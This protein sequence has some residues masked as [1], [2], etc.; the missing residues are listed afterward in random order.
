MQDELIAEV[1]GFK[2][3]MKR[4]IELLR[5]SHEKTLETILSVVASAFEPRSGVCAA[6]AAQA[7]AVRAQVERSSLP[8]FPPH[9]IR[10]PH[11]NQHAP[12]TRFFL[13]FNQ[14]ELSGRGPAE[15]EPSKDAQAPPH[16]PHADVATDAGAGEAPDDG[17]AA[18]ALQTGVPDAVEVSPPRRLPARPCPCGLRPNPEVPSCPHQASAGGAAGASSKAAPAAAEAANRKRTLVAQE[19][20]RKRP[21]PPTDCLDEPKP[22][23]EPEPEPRAAVSVVEV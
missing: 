14:Q 16:A 19:Q 22:E 5:A 7:L 23:P 21:P 3:E 2:R 1:G 4:D 17:T 13:S 9:G 11:T 8:S 20:R 10:W 15:A 6:A 12:R 18:P